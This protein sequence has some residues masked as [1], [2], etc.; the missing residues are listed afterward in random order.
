VFDLLITLVVGT[1]AGA[2]LWI[3]PLGDGRRDQEWA[4]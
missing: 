1:A 2:A 4:R 3:S